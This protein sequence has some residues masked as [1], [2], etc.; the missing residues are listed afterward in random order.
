[1]VIIQD[2]LL[3]SLLV[4]MKRP[5]V[6]LDIFVGRGADRGS[7]TFENGAQLKSTMVGNSCSTYDRFTSVIP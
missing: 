2:T 5:P 3:T 4:F 1:M 7:C 6:F